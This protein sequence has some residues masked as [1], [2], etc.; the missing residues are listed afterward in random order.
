VVWLATG[1]APMAPGPGERCAARP[2]AAALDSAA[3]PK[4]LLSVNFVSQVPS[5]GPMRRGAS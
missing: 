3:Q 2:R 1:D 5:N 4:E